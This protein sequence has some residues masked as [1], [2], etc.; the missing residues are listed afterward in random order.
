MF[1]KKQLYALIGVVSLIFK[2]VDFYAHDIHNILNTNVAEEINIY[3][4]IFGQNTKILYYSA[5]QKITFEN[6]LFIHLSV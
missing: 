5:T 3:F 4:P 1:S 6:T 2:R